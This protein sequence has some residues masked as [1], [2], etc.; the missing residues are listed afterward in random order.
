MFFKIDGLLFHFRGEME[1]CKNLVLV[2]KHKPVA[3][4]T[5]CGDNADA[6]PLCGCRWIKN[7]GGPRFKTEQTYLHFEGISVLKIYLFI[8]LLLF[9]K[10]V[11]FCV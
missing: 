1:K 2:L 6:P 8:N 10:S 3:E 4:L 11:L 9:C 7:Y 5:Y